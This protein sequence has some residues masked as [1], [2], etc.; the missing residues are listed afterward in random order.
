M[1]WLFPNY[2]VITQLGKFT[3]EMNLLKYF[4]IL[5]QF[6]SCIHLTPFR[7]KLPSSL[8]FFE[9]QIFKSLPKFQ[10]F[11]YHLYS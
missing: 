5:G 6:L 9:V 11:S 3:K 2:L 8:R 10:A 1:D 7:R 4:H